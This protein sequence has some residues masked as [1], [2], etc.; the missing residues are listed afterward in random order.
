MLLSSG[1]RHEVRDDKMPMVTFQRACL[2]KRLDSR[3]LHARF[4]GL[5]KVG[6]YRFATVGWTL[7]DCVIVIALVCGMMAALHINSQPFHPLWSNCTDSPPSEMNFPVNQPSAVDVV[8]STSVGIRMPVMVSG[9][10]AESDFHSGRVSDSRSRPSADV[11]RLSGL[12]EFLTGSR[13]V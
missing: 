9:R 1:G 2:R 12:L 4:R 5:E 3:Y 11:S 6:R 10:I 7:R 8:L 13:Q